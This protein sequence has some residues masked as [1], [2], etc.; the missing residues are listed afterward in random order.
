[1][2][3]I[4]FVCFVYRRTTAWRKG[5]IAVLEVQ[6]TGFTTCWDRSS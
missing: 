5:G 3:G 6:M 4:T 2:F 1:M